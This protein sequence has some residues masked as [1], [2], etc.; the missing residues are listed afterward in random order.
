M[1]AMPEFTDI[2]VGAK[3]R[4]RADAVYAFCAPLTN[5]Y[6]PSPFT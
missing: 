1:F 4:F 3:V 5:R 6:I 2:S